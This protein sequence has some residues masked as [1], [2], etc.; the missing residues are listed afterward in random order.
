MQLVFDSIMESH[1]LFKPMDEEYRQYTINRI[2]S[3]SEPDDTGCRIW[4][5]AKNN[6][7]YG[8]LSFSPENM[9]NKRVLTSAHRAHYM[10][11]HDVILP[12]KIVVM[13]TCDNP[14]CVEITHLRAGSHKDNCQD[15][16]AKGRNAKKYSEHKRVRKFTDDQI[17]EIRNA[18]G[19]LRVV[20]ERYGTTPGYVSRLRNGSRKALVA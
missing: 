6:R 5:A 4:N 18:L 17:R 14:S 19:K 20:A 13:H 12:R 9:A 3:Y 7:G 2:L 8:L 1:M 16:L 10:A 15:K 11:F